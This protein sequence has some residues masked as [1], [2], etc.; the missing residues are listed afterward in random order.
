[1]KQVVHNCPKCF[2]FTCN[3]HE[4]LCTQYG[5]GVGVGV[6]VG[7]VSGVGGV[8]GASA[9]VGSVGAVGG[10]GGVGAVAGAAAS[11]VNGASVVQS[12]PDTQQHHQPFDVQVSSLLVL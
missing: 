1:M 4:N 5:G 3:L 9:G 6:G 2:M 11:L 7:A 8:G 12:A 10:V